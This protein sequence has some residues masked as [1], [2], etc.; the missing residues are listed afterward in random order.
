MNVYGDQMIPEWDISLS[1]S[2][3]KLSVGEKQKLAMAHEPDLL[4]LDEPAAGLPPS[5]DG[6]FLNT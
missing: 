6:F 3:R 2:I 5:Q 1:Q 4:I